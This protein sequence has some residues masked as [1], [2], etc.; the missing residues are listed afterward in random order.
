MAFMKI[1][2][3]KSTL[4]MDNFW[5]FEPCV[6]RS[7][8]LYPTSSVKSKTTLMRRSEGGPGAG[9]STSKKGT[10]LCQF[11]LKNHPKSE[12]IVKRGAGLRNM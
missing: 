12:F 11:Q 10:F 2:P 1:F 7:K 3:K 9:P 6:Q 5:P 4:I 8:C